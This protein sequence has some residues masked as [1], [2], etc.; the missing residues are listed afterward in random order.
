MQSTL[1]RKVIYLMLRGARRAEARRRRKPAPRGLPARL[2]A[3]GWWLDA[4]EAQAAPRLMT[5]D[6]IKNPPAKV[7]ADE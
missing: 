5:V 6:S 1:D 3:D 7:T 2:T 4:P